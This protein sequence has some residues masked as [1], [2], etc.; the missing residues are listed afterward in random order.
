MKHTKIFSYRHIS[1]SFQSIGLLK[2]MIMKACTDSQTQNISHETSPATTRSTPRPAWPYEQGT[3][4]SSAHEMWLSRNRKKP[5]ILK[6]PFL[7]QFFAQSAAARASTSSRPARDKKQQHS[8]PPLLPTL[9]L[10]PCQRLP[11]ANTIEEIN[12]WSLSTFSTMPEEK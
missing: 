4:F 5:V 7:N 6:A 11:N 1:L 2:C 10:I 9:Q 8:A 3:T 12:L